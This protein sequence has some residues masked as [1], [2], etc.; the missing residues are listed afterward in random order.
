M[1]SNTAVRS[2][3]SVAVVQ[4]TCNANDEKQWWHLPN[5]TH[6]GRSFGGGLIESFT[7]LTDGVL[8]VTG[9]H[10]ANGTP[11]ETYADNLTAAQLWGP[12]AGCTCYQ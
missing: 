12:S 7:L 10:S 1:E 5:W 6:S 2:D 9:S 11:L 3:G 8:D 4:Q